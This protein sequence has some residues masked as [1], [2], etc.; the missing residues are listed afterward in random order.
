MTAAIV[1]LIAT[2]VFVLLVVSPV[3]AIWY[4]VLSQ[5]PR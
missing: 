2:I 4:G 1:R 3:A 5:M